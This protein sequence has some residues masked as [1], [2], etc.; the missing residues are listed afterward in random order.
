MGSYERGALL[1]QQIVGNRV[2]ALLAR[3]RY[4]VRLTDI[5]PLRVVRRADLLRLGMREMTYGW[6]IEMIIRA[7]R[8][9]L[10]IREVPVS[11]RRR[12]GGASKVS[13]NLRGTLKAGY[14]I[15][16]AIF[17]A[18]RDDTPL[19]DDLRAYLDRHPADTGAAS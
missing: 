13:G 15:T 3:W 12:A 6:P 10:I 9:G 8:A 7:V 19:P 4:G 2:A 16:R 14:R 18:G 11:Y 5:G 17:R 1:P